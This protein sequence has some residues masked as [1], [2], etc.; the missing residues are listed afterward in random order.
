MRNW[1]KCDYVSQLYNSL[2][3]GVRVSKLLRQN[4]VVV[5]GFSVN[6]EVTTAALVVLRL[7]KCDVCINR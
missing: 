4:G 1:V 3:H 7:I 5:Q 2:V 6:D